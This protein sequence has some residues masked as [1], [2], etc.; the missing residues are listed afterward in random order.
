M[1][2]ALIV[3]TEGAWGTLV[4]I[5]F[6]LPVMQV[7][8][9]A[10]KTYDTLIMM[11]N[12]HNLI[13]GTAIYIIAILFYNLFGMRVTQQFTAVHRTILE[14]VRTGCIW[15]AELVIFY[16]VNNKFGEEWSDWSYLQLGGFIFVLMGTFVYNQVIKIPSLVDAKPS[17]APIEENKQ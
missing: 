7:I 8:P 3:G 15:I 14:S 1:P 6:V 12:N 9:S 13:W 11:S 17:F 4:C 2:P 16:Y 10:E 5:F